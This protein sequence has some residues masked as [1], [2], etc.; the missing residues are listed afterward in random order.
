MN[1]RIF[2]CTGILFCIFI[3][4]TA[5][6]KENH[7]GSD[8][9]KPSDF[10]TIYVDSTSTAITLGTLPDDTVRSS[11]ITYMVGE[12]YD[13]DFGKTRAG[14]M[15][16]LYLQGMNMDDIDAFTLDSACFR[17]SKSSTY[18]Y[19]DTTV[20]QTFSLYE[21]S[22]DITVDECKN[23]CEKATIPASLTGTNKILDIE[24]PAYE[25]TV[26][27]YQFRL[28]DEF[29]QSFYTKVKDCYLIDSSLQYFDS[30]FIQQFKGIY[31]TTKNDTFND[32]H[33]VITHCTP[34]ITL[35]FHDS[36]TSVSLVFAPSPQAYDSPLSTDES[37]IYLQAINVFYH[38][39]SSALS[40]AMNSTGTTTSYVQGMLGAKT[41]LQF[42][43]LEAWKDHLTLNNDDP[44]VINMAKLYVPLEQRDS[45]SE[46][47]PLNFR[48]YDE[49]RNLIFSTISTTTDSSN[50][51]FNIH[52]FLLHL[53]NYDDAA[54]SYSY[55]LC[56]PEN[57]AYGNLF[58]IDGSDSN[59]LK[60]IIT[61]TK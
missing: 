54:D 57:N 18:V 39:Y 50:Y 11:L 56:V 41:T 28:G 40:G 45:W 4:I 13:D 21:L 53:Y 36:D 6:N 29:T 58:K 44:I 33:A 43:G 2:H 49:D 3:V 15:T 24:I 47:L 51:I 23:Y 19:G 14:I 32:V 8:M 46:Y 25:D 17:V 48:V 1:N 30:L 27:S 20:S 12:N 31:L 34:E 9:L 37:Q 55:E 60:L 38:D 35:Y 10:L 42:S 5:C 61:Y 52:N 16:R 26:S 59:K 22:Q 7:I